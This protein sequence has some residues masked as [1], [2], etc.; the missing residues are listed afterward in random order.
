MPEHLIWLLFAALIVGMSKG[1]LSSAGSLAVP[2]LA[3]FMNP[4]VA[5]ALLLPVF[6]ITDWFAVW[7]YRRD[8]S[9]R[10]IAILVPSILGGIAIATVIVPFTSEALL[11]AMTGGVGFWYCLRSW[12]GK[13]RNAPARPAD[14]PRGVF[15]GI[16]TGIT[17][18]ITH[19]GAPPSQA[20]R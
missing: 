1:G 18:F 12:F 13:G 8:Y 10:N 15:W 7:L 3:L 2:I 11:L 9:G 5:A 19:S 4:V 6:M 16:V 14:I 17:T 20:A